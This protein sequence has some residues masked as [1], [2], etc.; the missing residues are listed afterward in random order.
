[1]LYKFFIY[2]YAKIKIKVYDDKFN[3][4]SWDLHVPEIRVI[5]ELF[6]VFSIDS[7]LVYEKK[8]YLEVY[9]DNCA[10]KIVNTEMIDYLDGKSF[11]SDENKFLINWFYQH[12]VTIELTYAEKLMLLKLIKVKNT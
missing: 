3:T 6:T 11:K 9:L 7:L 8:H 2:L 12:C 4:I 1:M 10:Y 5:G